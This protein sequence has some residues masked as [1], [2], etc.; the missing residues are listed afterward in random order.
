M[1][2]LAKRLSEDGCIA[3]CDNLPVSMEIFSTRVSRDL[4]QMREQWCVSNKGSVRAS[5]S[6]IS[7]I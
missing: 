3:C 2:V 7:T 6:S 1:Q 4:F 5:K